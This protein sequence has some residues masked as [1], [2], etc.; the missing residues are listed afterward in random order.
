MAY[1]AQGFHGALVR[2]NAAQ[3]SMEISVTN[4][5]RAIYFVLI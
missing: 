5:F 4:W 3:L 1:G 2:Q